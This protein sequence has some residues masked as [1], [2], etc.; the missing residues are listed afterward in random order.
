M[1]I[2]AR[3]TGYQVA[4]WHV[5]STRFTEQCM[6]TWRQCETNTWRHEAHFAAVVRG[7]SSCHRCWSR[8]RWSRRCWAVLASSSSSLLLFSPRGCRSSVWA[9]TECLTA[10]RNCRRLY[11]SLWRCGRRVEIPPLTPLQSPPSHTSVRIAAPTAVLSGTLLRCQVSWCQ[12]SR[13]QRPSP[14]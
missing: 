8:K 7:W 5:H 9:P 11:A 3:Q 1:V 12:V 10:R 2:S 14:F 4:I 13:F 6:S